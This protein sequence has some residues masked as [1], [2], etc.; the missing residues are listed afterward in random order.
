[1]D[2]QALFQIVV[3]EKLHEKEVPVRDGFGLKQGTTTVGHAVSDFLP[4]HHSAFETREKAL[5][6][7]KTCF[8]I[9]VL[10]L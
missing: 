5:T 2:K 8:Q 7:K 10:R 6:V 3:V 9:D 4:C 1:M